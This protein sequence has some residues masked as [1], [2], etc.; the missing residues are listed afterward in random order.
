VSLAVLTADERTLLDS[1]HYDSEMLDKIPASVEVLRVPA[2]RLLSRAAARTRRGRPPT[3]VPERAHR[4]GKPLRTG[5]WQALARVIRYNLNTPD[6]YASWIYPAIRAGARYISEHATRNILSTSPPGSA[7]VICLRLKRHA[8]VNWI[9]DFRDPWAA[10]QWIEPWAIGFK[11]S[12]IRHFERATIAAADHIVFSTGELAVEFR[13]TF[14]ETITPK[15]H[16]VTNGFDPEDFASTP[17]THRRANDEILLCHTGTF[18]RKRSPMPFLQALQQAR[19]T[20]MAAARLRV[21]FIGGLGP[22]ADEAAD[23]LVQRRLERIAEIVPFIPHRACLLEMKRADVLLL[24]QPVTAIQVPAKSFEYMAAR[25]PI[26]A[27]STQGATSQLVLDNHLGWWARAGNV[28]DICTRLIE[29]AGYFATSDRDPWPIDS[30]TL[31]RFN[32]ER[33]VD[34]VYRLLQ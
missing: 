30:S 2:M 12:V 1:F 27:I 24:I 31:D 21:R 20:S 8:P 29:I 26:F 33:L 3:T 23:F 6:E 22:F 32:G 13:A 17:E 7:H 18:Y 28:D 11:R 4:P 5:R 15:I 9:A 34:E 10:R 19:D 14:G 25:R 16:V